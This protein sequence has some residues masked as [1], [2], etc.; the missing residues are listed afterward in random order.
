MVLITSITNRVAAEFE[1]DLEVAYRPED[2]EAGRL[3]RFR[4]SESTGL[5]QQ[6]ALSS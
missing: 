4:L 5:G 3:A 1:Q 6:D 2:L